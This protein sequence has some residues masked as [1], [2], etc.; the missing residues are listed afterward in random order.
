MVIGPLRFPAQ[1]EECAALYA[2]VFNAPP[3][4]DSWTTETA[5]LRLQDILQSPGCLGFG[6]TTQGRLVAC[7]L[8]NFEHYFRGPYFHLKEMCVAPACQR[9]GVGSLLLRELEQALAQRGTPS[10]LLFTSVDL[11]PFQFYQHHRFSPVPG[12]QMLFRE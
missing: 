4:N 9:Q 5:R 3:W 10:I 1:L 2:E 7:L 8:G 12:M 11:P 6:A